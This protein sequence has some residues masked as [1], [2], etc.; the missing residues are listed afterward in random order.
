MED[1]EWDGDPDTDRLRGNGN[2]MHRLRVESRVVTA[3][4]WSNSTFNDTVTREEIEA[5]RMVTEG[6]EEDDE[7]RL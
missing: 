3:P 7:D 2:R 6:S 5:E 4:E 1:S